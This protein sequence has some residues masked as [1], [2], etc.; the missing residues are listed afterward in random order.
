MINF[1]CNGPQP[2]SGFTLIELL[3]VVIII[4]ILGSIAAPGWLSFLERQRANAVRNDLLSVIREVQ[5]DAKQKSTE[6]TVTLKTT[7]EGPAVDISNSGGFIKTELLGSNA[8]SIKLNSF[9]GGN[10]DPADNVSE[11]DVVFD[12]RGGV[13]SVPFVVQIGTNDNPVQKCLIITTLLGGISEGSGDECENP[14]PES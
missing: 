6:R 9:I 5:E 7:T 3:V 14:I 13:D 2:E 8:K 12:Y 4:G 10:S 1:K 11:D